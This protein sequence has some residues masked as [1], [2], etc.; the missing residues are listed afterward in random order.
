M[1]NRFHLAWI[2]SVVTEKLSLIAV[3]QINMLTNRS[4]KLIKQKK[5]KKFKHIDLLWC[6]NINCIEIIKQEVF[7]IVIRDSFKHDINK[8]VAVFKILKYFWFE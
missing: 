4:L 2:N 7:F 8:T 3:S 1:D 5:K 6:I